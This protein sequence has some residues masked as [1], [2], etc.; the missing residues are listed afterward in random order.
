MGRSWLCPPA[1]ALTVARNWA[2]SS[3]KLAVYSS[4]TMHMYSGPPQQQRLGGHQHR[5]RSTICIARWAD[6]KQKR[7]W[8]KA[9]KAQRVTTQN[10]PWTTATL[11][12]YK[13]Q[14]KAESTAAFLLWTEILG[15]NT[16]LASIYVPQ[17]TPHCICGWPTQIVRHMLLFCNH[18]IAK[19]QLLTRAGT[20]NITQMLL[21]SRGLHAAA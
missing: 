12:L 1:A 8:K 2:S 11:P 9:V 13:G 16:W 20:S 6:T 10:T 3:G 5:Q 7:Q 21:T 4:F 18:R 19:D 15:L 14:S 17:I